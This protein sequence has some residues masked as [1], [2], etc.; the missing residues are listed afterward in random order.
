MP[1]LRSPIFHAMY[2]NWQMEHVK[3]ET[4]GRSGMV[5]L[6]DMFFTALHY[7][8]LAEI[9]EAPRPEKAPEVKPYVPAF[10]AT[11]LDLLNGRVP[12]PG[13]PVLASDDAAVAASL[14]E[15]LGGRVPAPT[16]TGT[17][18]LVSG[19]LVVGCP[20]C[21]LPF[22]TWRAQL[23]NLVEAPELVAPMR[24]E[25]INTTRCPQCGGG[26]FEP[27]R[28]W[29][30]EEPIPRDPL[31]ALSCC[32]VTSDASVAYQPVPGTSRHPDYDRVLEVR[33]TRQY[34]DLGLPQW[35]A[36][37]HEEKTADTVTMAVAYSGQD[38]KALYDRASSAQTGAAG[39]GGFPL[40]MEVMIND[41]T[42][43]VA[44]GFA[45]LGATL[46]DLRM[47]VA[48]GGA[49]WPIVP[50][51]Q[52]ATGGRRGAVRAVI[53]NVIAE[54]VAKARGVDPSLRVVLGGAT[55]QS[56][57][58]MSAHGLA[59]ASL[60]QA[61]ELAASVTDPSQKPRA[62]FA[63]LIA[64]AE[65]AQAL[66]RPE[67]SLRLRDE[68]ARLEES[69]SGPLAHPIH[70]LQ[71][72]STRANLAHA[73]GRPSKAVEV[74][75]GCIKGLESL[76]ASASG[77]P[78]GRDDER[79][80]LAAEHSLSVACSNWANVLIDLASHQEGQP[81]T[82]GDGTALG[83]GQTV[84]SHS[85]ASFRSEL[86]RA[87]TALRSL[88]GSDSAAL[89]D[90]GQRL[91]ERALEI[92]TRLE[93]W[94]HAG[95]QAGN[96]GRLHAAAGRRDEAI[97]QQRLAAQYAE[98]AGDHERIIWAHSQL[99]ALALDAGDGQEA[100][101]HQQAAARA[102]IHM[103]AGA[104][105]RIE[106]VAPILDEIAADVAGT[107]AHG[108]DPTTAFLVVETL[109]AFPT[110]LALRNA[111]PGRAHRAAGER[112]ADLRRERE[113]LRV[114][115]M[116]RDSR[117]EA[118]QQLGDVEEEIARIE[119][120]NRLNDPDYVRWCDSTGFEVTRPQDFLR[121]LAQVGS[122]TL[123][124][125]LLHTNA[126]VWSYLIGADGC[127]YGLSPVP[128][129]E[130]LGDAVDTIVLG[131]HLERLRRAGASTRLLYSP[132]AS[133]SRIPVAALFVDENP[134]CELVTIVH[135]QS[136]EVLAAALGRPAR[137]CESIA[138]LADPLRP[139]VSPLP[140]A[141][142]EAEEIA[143]E[144][145]SKNFP[146]TVRSGAKATVGALQELAAAAD[147]IHLACHA[148]E[149]VV[150][151]HLGRLLLAPDTE[152]GDSG[153][154]TDG[155]ILADVALRPGC[156]VSLAACSSGATSN[157]Q[158][159]LPRGLVGAFL[160]AGAG[161][162]LAALWPLADR[163]AAAFQVEFY[164]H[165]L[166]G[167]APAESLAATQRACA[168][169]ALGPEMQDVRVWAGYVIYGAG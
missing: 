79:T 161:A 84:S 20:D 17:P 50:A 120:E 143:S 10:F 78:G 11:V 47:M 148:D 7:R 36:S 53:M 27:L 30:Q 56:L 90:E 82:V 136:A 98:R 67:E 5:G 28:L 134:L 81:V 42:R 102:A 51:M 111:A 62:D 126:G 110:A 37:R 142:I 88:F 144:F 169:G 154:L 132:A 68:A 121:S 129:E 75:P 97:R 107:I 83:G 65:V 155:R 39:D 18:G 55:I 32:W 127:T 133:L 150:P 69:L 116:R 1:A 72:D 128:D 61:A 89:R 95:V 147:V 76:V 66:G 49:E 130:A 106:E 166:Q 57:L 6:Y 15:V 167:R 118:L 64:R 162:V 140:A 112:L 77:G 119:Q 44:D 34:E 96:L 48:A 149:D 125:G 26:V 122:G 4:P 146:A 159:Q 86:D 46:A 59:E 63:L 164:T 137:R 31:L 71:A 35:F 58:A 23:V 108:G 21:R 43:K 3:D 104:G 168:S 87:L 70:R 99:A 22:V 9:L 151:Q 153:D 114:Q 8:Q 60:A 115:L 91:Y 163:T 85:S 12:Q 124:L 14:A 2:R 13:P 73:L 24:E 93:A 113:T 157:N 19:L 41:L 29:L 94:Q 16:Y 156:L 160:Y 80:R 40:A 152:R 135:V 25:R 33:F 139:D 38:L 100:L 109:K 45:P 138:C 145:T 92:S 101:A 158:G 123:L 105:R 54:E 74:F 117:R 103:A 131:P 52:A 141:Y 165:L